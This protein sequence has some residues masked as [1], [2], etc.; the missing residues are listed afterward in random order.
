MIDPVELVKF[1]LTISGTLAALCVPACSVI[2]FITT[3]AE[4]PEDEDRYGPIASLCAVTGILFVITVLT[5]IFSLIFEAC[6][7]TYYYVIFEFVLGCALIFLIFLSFTGVTVSIKKRLPKMR[8]R[9]SLPTSTDVQENVRE[10]T[11]NV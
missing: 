10:P 8:K 7:S 2:F 6:S 11:E 4:D 5:S 9:G 1:I 3:N